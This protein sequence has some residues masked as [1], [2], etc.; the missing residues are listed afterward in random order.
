MQVPAA[1]AS[2]NTGLYYCMQSLVTLAGSHGVTSV[3]VK[4]HATLLLTPTSSQA[5]ESL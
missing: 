2:G 4:V 1:V 5:R 3:Y